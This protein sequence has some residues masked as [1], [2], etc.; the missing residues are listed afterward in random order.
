MATKPAK[1][2]GAVTPQSKTSN[3]MKLIYTGGGNDEVSTSQTSFNGLRVTPTETVLVNQDVLATVQFAVECRVT[4]G[5]QLK[6]RICRTNEGPYPCLE[7]TVVL[8]N[9]P[10]YETHSHMTS[11]RLP[12]GEHEIY[13]EWCVSGGK[14]FIRY[15]FFTVILSGT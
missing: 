6:A 1:R 11:F 9:S 10:K 13:L 14:G 3:I 7:N 5:N 8:T 12:P 4:S 2:P 15:R